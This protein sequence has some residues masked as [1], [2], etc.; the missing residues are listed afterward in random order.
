[1]A[2]TVQEYAQLSAASYKKELENK[3]KTDNFE[4]INK[5]I[6]EGENQP[7]A[8]ANDDP[9]TGFSANVYRKNNSNEIV[10]AFTGSNLT[11]G[12]NGEDTWF[13]PLTKDFTEAN[14][15]QRFRWP[16]F[17]IMMGKLAVFYMH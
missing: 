5:E 6:N 16:V 3:I 4:N 11:L 1:M 15:K 9:K 17:I 14:Y 13:I 8:F 10:I 7:L 12:E 2:L